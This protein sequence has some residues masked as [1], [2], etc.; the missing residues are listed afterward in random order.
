M[1]GRTV[2]TDRRIQWAV[3]LLL[4][5][6]CGVLVGLV[7]AFPSAVQA[8]SI[9]DEPQVLPKLREWVGSV[10][11][12]E[13]TSTSQILINS[14]STNSVT[15]VHGVSTN[16]QTRA[17]NLREQLLMT[18]GLDLTV[19]SGSSPSEGDILLTLLD[20]ADTTLGDEGYRL[21]IQNYVEIEANTNSGIFYAQQTILQILKHTSTLRELPKGVATD[22]PTMS[23]RGVMLDAGRKY[24]EMDF[25]EETIRRMAWHKLNVL[26]MHFTEWNG[27]RLDSEA[28]PDLANSDGAYTRA[29]ID[30]L[31][32]VGRENHLIILPEV[33]MPGHMNVATEWY[34]DTYPGETIRFTAGDCAGLNKDPWNRRWGWNLNYANRDARDFAKSL[35]SEFAPWFDSPYFH[36]GADETT[37]DEDC[38]EIERWASL[39]TNG[40]DSKVFSNFVNEMNDHLRSLGKETHIWNGYER[41]VSAITIDRDI[42]VYLWKVDDGNDVSRVNKLL[43]AGLDIVFTPQETS[44]RLYLTPNS[45]LYPLSSGF[46]R[47]TLLTSDQVRGYQISVWP[48]YIEGHPDRFFEFQLVRPR[49]VLAERLW[50]GADT[51][52]DD[53]FGLVKRMYAIGGPQGVPILGAHDGIS[54]EDWSIHAVSS[55]RSGN[56][57]RLLI[58]M[59][60]TDPWRAG[61]QGYPHYVDVNL[62]HTY[63]ITS[64]QALQRFRYSDDRVKLVDFYVS[65]DGI[66]WGSRVARRNFPDDTPDFVT[67]D[68]STPVRGRYVRVQAG[69]ALHGGKRAALEEINVFGTRV[70]YDDPDENLLYH[71]ALDE[72]S[73]GQVGDSQGQ[74]NGVRVG[75]NWI[76]GRVGNHALQFDGQDDYVRV[77]LGD[78]SGDWTVALWAKRGAD[79]PNSSALAIL[80]SERYALLL[81]QYESSSDRVG[82]T[83]Y[84]YQGTDGFDVTFPYSAPL[85]SWVHLAFVKEGIAVKLYADGK[86]I[87]EV[88]RNIDLPLDQIGRRKAYGF[89]PTPARNF[90]NG[91]LDDIRI[92]DTA[93]ATAQIEAIYNSYIP[94]DPSDSLITRWTF[95]EGIGRAVSDSVGSYHGV[96]SGTEWEAGRVGSNALWFDGARDYVDVGAGDLS[97]DWSVAVWARRDA[98]DDANSMAILASRRYALKLQQFGSGADAVGVS[99]YGVSGTSGTD[100]TFNYSAPLDTWVHLVFVGRASSVEL[101]VNGEYQDSESI[102]IDLPRERIGARDAYGGRGEI[103]FLEGALDD[104]RVYDTALTAGQVLYLYSSY[105]SIAGRGTHDCPPCP[106]A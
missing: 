88:D 61:S 49:A 16:V 20:T 65:E 67:A 106:G 84:D 98:D 55:S 5:T 12:F 10:G 35:L 83:R 23:H 75:A 89:F 52:S 80:T 41:E 99:R 32:R 17:A 78:Q 30:R 77:N 8:Q 21:S 94:E 64:I 38:S 45:D 28:F 102:D 2:H 18:T 70:T 54:K 48:D 100:R 6:S 11:T 74:T 58:D 57:A 4:A 96:R 1:R 27:F 3:P 85:Y 40:D 86:L 79:A 62:G 9:N 101:Y 72:G 90:L 15:T 37:Y 36:I 51:K 34:A 103:D 24:W 68:L 69:S 44:Y 92:Y 95:D 22:Y 56:P 43:A 60:A 81:Q 14:T 29:D 53:L 46:L 59:Q 50:G 66:N 91:E 7:L 71:W 19:V 97:G 76:D 63:D 39:Y 33:D 82:I 26:H 47:Y 31:Q 42:V 87:G 105:N 13:L 93:L 104:L 73:G 25:L